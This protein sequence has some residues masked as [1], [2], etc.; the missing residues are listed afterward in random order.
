MP[1][2]DG[3]ELQAI[4]NTMTDVVIMADYHGT[5]VQVNQAV[6]PM[7]GYQPS[8]LIGQNISVLMPEAHANAHQSYMARYLQ[9]GI[10][11]IIGVGRELAAKHKDSH[12]FPIHISVSKLEQYPFFIAVIRDMS[13]LVKLE[14]EA[15]LISEI[16]RNR[17]SR[18][19]H[20]ELGQNLLGLTM[21]LQ[22]ITRQLTAAD[23]Q[24]Q[25][26]LQNL[27]N[28]L[29]HNVNNIRAIISELATVE[30]EEQG[31][32][33]ALNTFVKLCNNYNKAK[34][35]LICEGQRPAEDYTVTINLYRIARE[36]IYNALKHADASQIDVSLKQQ[37]NSIE[38]VIQ[39]NGKGLP[40][41]LNVRDSRLIN[42]GHGLRNIHFRAHVIGA[43]L[44]ISSAAATGTRI[45]CR[46]N[47]P[48]TKLAG[49]NA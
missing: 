38:L 35:T 44:T 29:A 9:A 17:I 3:E 48:G 45:V 30:L 23:Y 4:L 25:L 28:G 41:D 40:S 39:D 13:E 22:V 14:K 33:S 36:A 31:L 18:E 42:S 15:L 6:E 47:Q 5:V 27:S 16:E 21:Q 10:P 7:F 49:A 2:T 43:E 8:L 24:L 11:R 12:L 46:Y 34:V 26:Q 19:L 37:D 1:D 20:D 32:Q